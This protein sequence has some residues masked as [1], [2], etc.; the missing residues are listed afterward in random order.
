LPLVL[1]DEFTYGI[2]LVVV[3]ELTRRA[4]HLV[5]QD[6]EVEA[7]G[8][9]GALEGVNSCYVPQ[10]YGWNNQAALIRGCGIIN[11]FTPEWVRVGLMPILP[12]PKRGAFAPAVRARGPPPPAS[13][14]YIED[15]GYMDPGVSCRYKT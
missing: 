14:V 1:A 10:L 5:E 9:A 15:D 6:A 7:A 8:L 12:A 11:A 4:A 13:P 2:S 3:Y